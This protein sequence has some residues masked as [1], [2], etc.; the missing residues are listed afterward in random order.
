[1]GAYLQH[2]QVDHA[3]RLRTFC[4]GIFGPP[5]ITIKLDAHTLARFAAAY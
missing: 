4:R 1:M 3:A 2:E 5:R